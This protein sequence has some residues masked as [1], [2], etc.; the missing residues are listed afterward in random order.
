MRRIGPYPEQ[1]NSF[2]VTRPTPT[3]FVERPGI[4]SG[5]ATDDNRTKAAMSAQADPQFHADHEGFRQLIGDGRLNPAEQQRVGA[6]IDRV[7][8]HRL[9]SQQGPVGSEAHSVAA[10]DLGRVAARLAQQSPR[11]AA[12]L[13]TYAMVHDN[14]ARRSNGRVLGANDD[15]AGIRSP[16]LQPARQAAPSMINRS[17]NGSKHPVQHRPVV[18]TG[19]KSTPTQQAQ[20][21][22]NQRR[23]VPLPPPPVE[24]PPYARQEANGAITFDRV[25]DKSW[26]DQWYLQ[27]QGR[28]INVPIANV[29][30]ARGIVPERFK[31][32]RTAL[33]TAR[34]G[35]TVHIN[36]IE[37]IS[38]AD[39]DQ[40]EANVILHHNWRL[41]GD[42]VVAKNG[43]YRFVGHIDQGPDADLYN[44]N[45]QPRGSLVRNI[46]TYLGDPSH[47]SNARSAPYRI[48]IHGQMPKSSRG[49]IELWR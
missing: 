14:A 44:F 30:T 32:V 2:G 10:S 11:V 8:A 31:A 25:P 13:A 29:Q 27:G 42:V 28:A 20:A 34:P 43:A 45:W 18:P 19:P 23:S 9:G 12:P 37:P 3:P 7:N 40:T 15:E 49:T 36:A 48:N 33:Q 5:L 16:S 26:A 47:F 21:G 22:Q 17:T 38:S 1:P 6:I 35:T 46:A 39:Y 41:R 24:L 4:G